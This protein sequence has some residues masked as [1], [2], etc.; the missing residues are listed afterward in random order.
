MISEFKILS[1]KWF[2]NNFYPS[3]LFLTN[4]LDF[5]LSGNNYYFKKICLSLLLS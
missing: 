1:D 5:A 3:R 4:K 2:V